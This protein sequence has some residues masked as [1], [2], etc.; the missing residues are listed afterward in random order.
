MR[1]VLGNR[2]M[3]E[4]DSEPVSQTPASAFAGHVVP[5]GERKERGTNAISRHMTMRDTCAGIPL[6]PGP[7]ARR[8]RLQGVRCLG[9]GVH[10]RPRTPVARRLVH[11]PGASRGGHGPPLPGVWCMGRGRPEASTDPRPGALP[12]ALG[13]E[14][15]GPCARDVRYR[16]PTDLP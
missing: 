6:I 9:R 12:H 15:T 11:G 16:D 7:G 14:R 3:W 4:K 2:G 1:G 5:K 8:C 13:A 10:R